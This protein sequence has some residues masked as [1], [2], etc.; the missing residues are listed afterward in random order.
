MPG[1]VWATKWAMKM[2]FVGVLRGEGQRGP[3]RGMVRGK[4]HC[5]EGG[6]VWEC[7]KHPVAGMLPRKNVSF[8][9]SVKVCGSVRTFMLTAGCQAEF[10][11]LC[12]IS[13]RQ[14]KQGTRSRGVRRAPHALQGKMAGRQAL[15]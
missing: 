5:S 10:L 14:G 9:H 13:T 1:T 15:G 2:I 6:A 4:G 12:F 11:Y 7:R 8:R 3:T